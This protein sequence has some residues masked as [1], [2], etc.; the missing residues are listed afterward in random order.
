MYLLLFHFLQD[1]AESIPKPAIKKF[2]I[3]FMRNGN[4]NLVNDVIKSI[5][6]SNYKIDQVVICY[7]VTSVLDMKNVLLC[8]LLYF[9]STGD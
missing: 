1:N 4:I 2:A 3:S 5:H 6:N 9:S 8:L 7:Y